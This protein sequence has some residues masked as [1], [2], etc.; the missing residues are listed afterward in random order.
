MC[1]RPAV[2]GG[3]KRAFYN[4]TNRQDVYAEVLRAL[5]SADDEDVQAALA[6]NNK[7][8]LTPQLITTQLEAA[9]AAV[10][11]H[12]LLAADASMRLKT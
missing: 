2:G 4:R 3:G 1:L 5:L 11:T 12:P 10:W 8:Q 9:A 6:A 7:E